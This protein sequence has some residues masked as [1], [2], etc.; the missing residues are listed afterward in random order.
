MY[1]HDVTRGGLPTLS[2]WRVNRAQHSISVKYDVVLSHRRGDRWVVQFFCA[3]F[4]ARLAC[5]PRPLVARVASHAL[6]ISLS[7]TRYDISP[8]SAMQRQ[9]ARYCMQLLQQA[10]CTAHK[11]A[12]CMQ[13]RSQRYFGSYRCFKS[14]PC[15]DWMPGK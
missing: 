2:L 11:L 13:Y 14:L 3:A 7:T 4:Y 12:E 15:Y 6:Q 10:A 9:P 8:F 5:T 1:M